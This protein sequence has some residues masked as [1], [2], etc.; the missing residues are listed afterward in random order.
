MEDK[1]SGT[2]SRYSM[3]DIGMAAFSLFFMQHPSFLAFQRSLYGH[4]GQDN[5][6]TLFGM[7]KIP[8][9]NH[10][11]NMLDGVSP[12]H[13]D[14]NFFFMLDELENS[15]VRVVRNVLAGSTLIALDGSEYHCSQKISCPS[16]SKRK[17]SDARE[18]YFHS[19]LGAT[20]VRPGDPRVFSLPPEFIQNQDG[21]KKQDC[22]LKAARRWFARIAPLCVKY[23]PVYLGDDLYSKHDFCNLVL[24]NG[25]SFIFTCKDSSHKTLH[26]F[27]KGLVP[28]THVEVSG[29]GD[30]KREY[31]YS[32]LYNLPI[33]DGTHALPVNWIDVNIVNPKGKTTYHASFITNIFPDKGNISELIMCARA[34]WK[35]ENETFN[36]LKNNGYHLEHNFGHGQQTLSAVLVTLNLLAFAL[37][38]ACDAVESLWQKARE[39]CGA[40]NRMFIHLWNI[41]IYHVFQTWS[42]LMNTLITG[43]PPPPV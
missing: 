13:F 4:K 18:E 29:K 23:N 10:I 19:F 2:N 33:R 38:N 6:Q 15:K 1:R 30:Q 37:H 42:A 32:W 31:H 26:E 21:D 27:R 17:H 11:R 5:T 8:S 7:G 24:Q 36:V 9:D 22:E 3:A 34:R 12:E 14:E 40:R 25:G 43:R 35:I 41:T 20:I 28:E 16:C 39:I